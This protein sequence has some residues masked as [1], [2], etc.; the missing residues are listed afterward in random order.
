L[1]E[2]MAASVVGCFRAAT[3]GGRLVHAGDECLAADA[4]NVA[5]GRLTRCPTAGR[6]AGEQER[7]PTPEPAP[8]SAVREDPAD[9]LPGAAVEDRRP[10][11][12]ANDLALVDPKAGDPWTGEHVPK[13]GGQPQ[14]A[15]RRADAQPLPVGQDAVDALAVQ[16]PLSR[17][18]DQLGFGFL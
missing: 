6:T 5:D 13:R 14:V 16:Q 1:R 10:S 15:L 7:S 11:S 18:A 3:I 4:L 8:P 9:G 2:D 12:G 17:L